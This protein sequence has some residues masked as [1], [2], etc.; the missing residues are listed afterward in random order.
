MK[1]LIY[2]FVAALGAALFVS[3]ADKKDSPAA[4]GDV[5]LEGRWNVWFDDQQYA[6][7][8]DDFRLSY[9]FKGNKVDLYIIAWGYHYSGV[10]TFNDNKLSF[11]MTEGKRAKY[12]TAGSSGWW[13]GNMDRWTFELN[14]AEGYAWYQMDQEEYN[15]GEQY[16]QDLYLRFDTATKGH[17]SPDPEETTG[18]FLFMKVN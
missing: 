10:Y 6:S 12:V 17:A 15:N 18:G 16:F 1:K 9:I 14:T 7:N 5:S 8:P 2:L 4:A 11:N 13:N 3:C